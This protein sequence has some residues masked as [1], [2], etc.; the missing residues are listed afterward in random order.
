[1]HDDLEILQRETFDNFIHKASPANGFIRDKAEA[2][3]PASSPGVGL[4]TLRA[5]PEEA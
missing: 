5:V 3:W 2:D 4:W 1:M